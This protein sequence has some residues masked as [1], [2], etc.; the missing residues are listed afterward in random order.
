VNT[1]LGKD[2]TRTVRI[3]ASSK[4]VLKEILDE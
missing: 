2:I 3:T 4:E 1:D